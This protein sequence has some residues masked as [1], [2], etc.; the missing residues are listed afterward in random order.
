MSSEDRDEETAAARAYEELL[1]TGLFAEWGP[2]VVAAARVGPGDRVLDVGCGTGVAARAAAEKVGSKGRVTGLDP[3]AGMLAV[4]AERAP[5][6][7]W[8]Q[9]V[10][11][12]LPEPDASFDVV[13][14]QFALMF[15]EDRRQALQEMGRVLRPGGR[16]ALAV[17]DALPGNAAY[18]AEVDVLQRVAADAAADA[19]RAPFCLGSSNVLQPLFQEA[20]WASVSVKAASGRARFDSV[21]GMV[22]PDLRGWLPV[23]GVELGE[24]VI[25]RVLH[26]A[27]GA[28]EPFV[29]PD[30]SVSFESRALLVS[31]VRPE[32]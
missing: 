11:E 8:R 30:G 24:D 20:G 2:R 3:N 25:E 23:M 22:T 4:A 19:M 31:A 5:R 29:E 26:E 16:L 28:L 27:E 18:A 12:S 7:T 15:F 9:A 14:S 17:W 10:A 21:R 6:V 13:L 32:A 1:V